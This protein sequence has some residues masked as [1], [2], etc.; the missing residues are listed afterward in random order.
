MSTIQTE[1]P[2]AETRKKRSL[3][4]RLGLIS[5]PLAALAVVEKLD[6]LVFISD[7]TKVVLS[8]WNDWTKVFWVYI[9]SFFNIKELSNIDAVFLTFTLM[10]TLTL[11]S[12]LVATNPNFTRREIVRG[13]FFV[14]IG[15]FILAAFFAAGD[16]ATFNREFSD[17]ETILNYDKTLQFYLYSQY[18]DL[19][20]LDR[21][22]GATK[23][24]QEWN[25]FFVFLFYLIVSI[26]IFLF[27]FAIS[28]LFRLRIQ[29]WRM[30]RRIYLIIGVTV[31]VLAINFTVYLWESSGSSSP[32]TNGASAE[33]TLPGHMRA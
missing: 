13:S 27:I 28:R 6:A 29:I 30:A 3:I 1:L 4:E 15:F 32:T 19:L 31:V 33:A 24:A 23:Y 5:S 18:M 17:P 21:M 26:C 8:H 14:C 20:R 16:I 7:F 9:L 10:F 11:L 12:S 25:V 2:R 22:V